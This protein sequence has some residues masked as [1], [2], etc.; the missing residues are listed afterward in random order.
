MDNLRSVWA[1]WADAPLSNHGMNQARACGASFSTTRLTH[2]YASPLKRAFSTAQAILDAQPEPKPLFTVSP[3]VREQHFGIAEGNPWSYRISEADKDLTREQLYERRIFPILLNREDRFPEGE[4]LSDLQAR[5]G[6]AIKDIVLPYVKEGAFAG[7]DV[8]IAIVSHGLCISELVSALVRLD[9][10]KVNG[11]DWTGLL[12]TAWTRVTL[13]AVAKGDTG[14]S[15]PLKVRVTHVNEHSHLLNI[16]RQGGGIGSSAHDPA[17]QDIR[18]FFGGAKP[19]SKVETQETTQASNE[20]IDLTEADTELEEGRAT[21][22]V[23]D[24]VGIAI[25]KK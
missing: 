8:H 16:K 15:I 1:G 12:N 25:E 9:H 6:R 19:S 13:D 11:S 24:E 21:S 5:A 17:Q 4:S 2:I 14:T 7:E 3:D 18:A 23:Y 22:N 20:V 10:F